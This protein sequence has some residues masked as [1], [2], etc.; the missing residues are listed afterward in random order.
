MERTKGGSL[1][2]SR[3]FLLH[4]VYSPQGGELRRLG[5]RKGTAGP[6]PEL[7][8]SQ[9]PIGSGGAQTRAR[10]RREWSLLEDAPA[11]WCYP[12]RRRWD[13]GCRAPRRS[14]HCSRLTSALGPGR[15]LPDSL[16]T[17][18]LRKP[19]WLV[20]GS[21]AVGEPRIPPRAL[22]ILEIQT[23]PFGGCSLLW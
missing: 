8:P 21:P 2:H 13:R 17:L 9:W 23:T 12:R 6:R 3:G 7:L 4:H 15:T 1:L 16:P 5:V 22:E 20:G 19:K 18:Q 11:A 14:C 10:S